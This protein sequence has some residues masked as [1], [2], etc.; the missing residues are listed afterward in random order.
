M[1][2]RLSRR[3][4]AIHYATSL[5]EGL[6]TKQLTKELAAYLVESKRT[7]ELSLIISDIEYQLGLMGVV[8]ARVT[9]AH[10]LDDIAKKALIDLVRDKTGA[11]QIHLNENLDP[12][13]LGGMKLEFTGIELDT[14]IARRLAKLK[15]NF[16]L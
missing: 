5:I 9:S 2:V 16:K 1:A 15:T 12:K 14:T 11:R 7:K 13:V 4:I 6:D 3:K 8:S 10:I